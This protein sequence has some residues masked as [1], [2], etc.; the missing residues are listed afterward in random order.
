MRKRITPGRIYSA[1]PVSDEVRRRSRNAVM[2][3]NENTT[4]TADN[5]TE[6]TDEK[7][8]ISDSFKFEQWKKKLLE[9][10]E[11]Q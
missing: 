3:A 2:H 9:S 1:H 5:I 11:K 6:K 8:E 7:I 4:D 10:E